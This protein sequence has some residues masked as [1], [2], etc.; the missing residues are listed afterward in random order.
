MV[1]IKNTQVFGLERAVVASGNP[2]IVGEIDTTSNPTSRDWKRAQGLGLAKIG[3]GHDNYLSGVLVTFDLKYPQ[4]FSMELQRYHFLQIVSSE[5]KM[6][7]LT[8][9]MWE[10][11]KE[12][13]YNDWVDQSVIDN[14][15]KYVVD[16]NNNT[17]PEQRYYSFMKA[18]SNLPMGYEMWMTVTTNYLQLKTIYNQRRNHKLKDDWGPFCDWI[19]GLP[20][21]NELVFGKTTN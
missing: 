11:N 14:V 5:S 13:L 3:S 20:H 12:N 18:V 2:M 15:Q 16:Y 4:Y 21:F 17:D 6:H 1:K 19:E 7:R 9:A 8:T 10:G